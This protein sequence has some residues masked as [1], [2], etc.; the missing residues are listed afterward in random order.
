[1]RLHTAATEHFRISSDGK[2]KIGLVDNANPTEML[3]VVA[4]AVNQ[5]IARFTG[6]NRDRGLVISTAVSGSTNDSLIKYN[7]D[8]Q[9]SVGQH[10][11]L[12]D[13]DEKLSI[14][15]NGRVRIGNADLTAS[16][17]ADDLIVGTTSGSCLLYTSPSPRD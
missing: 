11:F 17:S 8:S 16:S 9:N 3:H 12:T 10:V 2:V 5:D 1:M 7:A 13:G 6:A 4:K 15:A 14:D